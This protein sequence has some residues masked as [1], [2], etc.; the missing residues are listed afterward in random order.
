MGRAIRQKRWREWSELWHAFGLRPQRRQVGA[1]TLLLLG[2]IGPQLL[3]P[4][5]MRRFVDSAMSGAPDRVLALAAGLF[6]LIAL[7]QQAASVGATYLSEKI[8]WTA[9]NALR[10]AL[11]RHCLGLDPS[12]HKQHT[13]VA[14]IE[15]IDGDA[16]ALA[17]FFSRL[18]I[19]ELLPFAPQSH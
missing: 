9:T 6:L 1:L 15:R 5:V 17:G 7:I 10:A 19:H 2:S 4:Q 12:F 16:T 13:P 11:L 14:L 8:G 18:V 3:N